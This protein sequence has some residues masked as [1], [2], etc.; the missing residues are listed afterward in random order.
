MVGGIATAAAV[1]S[2]PFRV[3]SFP[4]DIKPFVYFPVI[5]VPTPFEYPAMFGGPP[6]HVSIWRTAS[7][8]IYSLHEEI[9]LAEAKARYGYE[10]SPGYSNLNT[11]KQK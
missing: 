11:A 3:F 9:S 7:G 8:S 6:D 1:R 4:K 10:W 5:D 2:F